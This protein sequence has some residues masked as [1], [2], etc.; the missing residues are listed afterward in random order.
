MIEQQKLLNAIADLI[1]N[2]EMVTTVNHVIQPINA[3]NLRGAHAMIEQ[4]S[5]I[6][7]MVLAGWS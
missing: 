6:G 3:E 5:S 1:D 2:R 4:G 7:I